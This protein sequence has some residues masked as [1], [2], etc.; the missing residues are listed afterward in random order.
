MGNVSNFNLQKYIDDYQTNIFLETGVGLGFSLKHAQKFNFWHL[1]SIG[2][3]LKEVNNAKHQFSK[4]KRVTIFHESSVQVLRNV[5]PRIK[6]NIVF[7]LDAHL[8]SSYFYISSIA[9]KLHLSPHLNLCFP[10]EE[11]L[12]L[13]FRLR[14]LYKDIILIDDLSMYENGLFDS[15]NLYGRI[16]PYLKSKR[17]FF[18]NKFAK[19]YHIH[20]LYNDNGYIEM[21]PKKWI[22]CK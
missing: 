22:I 6:Q 4:D 21:L 14:W 13:I 1:I 20:K 10:L 15:G 3:D 8:P 5:L 18:L 16:Y 17:L 2:L 7:W 9:E 11:E 19:K 12:N